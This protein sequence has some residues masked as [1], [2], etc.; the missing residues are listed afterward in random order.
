MFGLLEQPAS[1]FSDPT[2]PVD[3]FSKDRANQHF[4]WN[5]FMIVI[6]NYKL[7]TDQCD[8]RIDDPAN[9]TVRA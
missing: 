6:D 1:L 2:D 7:P 8:R 9:A 5:Q 4:E 3:Y